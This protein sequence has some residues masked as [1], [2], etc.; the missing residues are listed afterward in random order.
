MPSRAGSCNPPQ[1]A[2]WPRFTAL[3]S[4]RF[5]AVN[6]LDL[7]ASGLME[8]RNIFPRTGNL[9][10]TPNVIGCRV[11]ELRVVKPAGGIRFAGMRRLRSWAVSG[12]HRWMM[13]M[14][15]AAAARGS[16]RSLPFRRTCAWAIPSL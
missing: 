12:V 5:G 2:L 3:R 1:I 6:G 16:S 8:Q 13:G 15:A 14:T 4:V 9:P 10:A 11:A 7:R